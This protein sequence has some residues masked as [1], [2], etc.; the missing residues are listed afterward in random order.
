[1]PEI[2]RKEMEFLSTE[3]NSWTEAGII[4]PEQS[5]EILSQYDVKPGNLRAVMLTA[6]AVLLGLGAVSFLLAHWHEIDKTL[7]AAVIA[8]SYLAS[9]SAYFV[10]GRETKAGKSFLILSGL[11]F[12]GGM[13]LI[14]R[15]YDIP[16]TLGE[17][18]GIWAAVL[19]LK[20]AITRD[21][22]LMYLAQAVSLAWLHE[23]G[24]VNT[25]ALYFVRTARVPVTE[26]FAAWPAFLLVGALWLVWAGTKDR[27]AFMMCVMITALLFASRMSLCFGGTWTLIILAVTG[28]VMSFMKKFPDAE[29]MGLLMLGMS[30]LLLTWPMFWRGNE[31]ASYRDILPVV[32]AVIVAGIMLVNIWRG[33]SGI[34][35]V[36]F[37]LLAARYFFDHLF[38]YLPK[39]WGFTLTG[40]IFVVLG[41]SFGR[42]R[43]FLGK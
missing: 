22:W 31:F 7:R 10:I 4:T 9:L 8:G 5:A 12:G 30:G 21:E 20:S 28:A 37:V 25:L 16:L 11:V 33:H 32:N 34:G 27:P 36:F 29:I 23:T 24:A 18:L 43:K 40:I 35:A 26:F 17:F 14:T 42:V 41:L 1:M 15:M 39:A 6:G 13:Y 38:G 3:V 19:L 2:R